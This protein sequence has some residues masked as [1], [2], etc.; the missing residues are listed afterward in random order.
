MMF[1]NAHVIDSIGFILVSYLSLSERL[2]VDA[3][4]PPAPSSSAVLPAVITSGAL[5]AE[6]LVQYM[7]KCLPSKVVRLAGKGCGNG[8]EHVIEC[9]DSNDVNGWFASLAKVRANQS[10]QATAS[11]QNPKTPNKNEKMNK[12]ADSLPTNSGEARSAA[13]SGNGVK[14]AR[15][16][17][18]TLGQ[19]EPTQVTPNQQLRTINE[20]GRDVRLQLGGG[21][22]MLGY[23]YH[24]HS[25]M[26]D[27]ESIRKALSFDGRSALTSKGA[28]GNAGGNDLLPGT[29][30]GLSSDLIDASSPFVRQL[31]HGTLAVL[32]EAQNES[33][34]ISTIATSKK[35]VTALKGTSTAATDSVGG[36][37][38]GSNNLTSADVLVAAMSLPM[39]YITWMMEKNVLQSVSKPPDMAFQAAH[40]YYRYKDPW[41]VKVLQLEQPVL[42]AGAQGA[43]ASSPSAAMERVRLGRRTY[44][45][46]TAHCGGYVVTPVMQ[47][48][49]N[50]QT[51]QISRLQIPQ[52]TKTDPNVPGNAADAGSQAERTISPAGAFFEEN[53]GI[54]FRKLWESL[55]AEA[56]LVTVISSAFEHW[57][58]E[59]GAGGAHDKTQR[60]L[61]HPVNRLGCLDPYQSCLS[62]YVYRNALFSRL[63]LPHRFTVDLQVDAFGL[64][65]VGTSSTKMASSSSSLEVYAVMRLTRC[66]RRGTEAASQSNEGVGVLGMS[67]RPLPPGNHFSSRT[68]W[69]GSAMTGTTRA[70][71]VKAPGGS[72][73]TEYLWRDQV[74]FRFAIP[75]GLATLAHDDVSTQAQ[76]GISSGLFVPPRTLLVT[77]YER[78]FFSDTKLGELELPLSSLTDDRAF[79][80]WLP[81]SNSKHNTP[82]AGSNSTWFV[83]LQVQL[84]FA[85]MAIELPPGRIP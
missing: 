26:K 32:A 22:G 12:S 79:R 5:Q 24:T 30:V 27:Q 14:K 34:G 64:K 42:G 39:E 68:P 83:H 17:A 9:I 78:N 55:R 1:P 33:S 20:R 19:V 74:Q 73:G 44:N 29:D 31:F 71:S 43:N 70:E 15:S 48:Y 84:K 7:Q 52:P 18:S 46:V 21:V 81:L 76:T 65:E 82:K 63:S 60:T 4:T 11:N 50:A 56:W 45:P 16:V 35:E 38:A 61:A 72:V 40:L 62:R 3:I 67:G 49:S 13:M 69:D 28:G 80:D 36:V 2:L 59:V 47:A 85:M 54:D 51:R 6:A 37:N 57:E 77:V 66:S 8:Q 25:S 10:Q 53:Y 75:E 23:R 58:R 41:E